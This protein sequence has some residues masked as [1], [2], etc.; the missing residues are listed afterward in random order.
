MTGSG[1]GRTRPRILLVATRSIDRHV[2]GSA[3]RAATA[4]RGL[5]RVG[6]VTYVLIDEQRADRPGAVLDP[7]VVVARR[8]LSGVGYRWPIVGSSLGARGPI[9]AAIAN[10][11]WEVPDVATSAEFDLGWFVKTAALQAWSGPLPRRIVLDVDDLEEDTRPGTPLRRSVDRMVMRGL[12]DRLAGKVDLLIAC[13]AAD[14]A[15]L[16]IGAPSA[17]VPN[18]APEVSAPVGPPATQPHLLFVGVLGYPPNRDGLTWFVRQVLPYLRRLTPGLVVRVV[19]PGAQALPADVRG[20]LE[21]VGIVADL[22]PHYAWSRIVVV[23]VLTGSGT[24]VKILDAFA[25][26]RGVVS[27]T[28]G[29]A[30]LE[31]RA[32]VDALIAD[33][34]R[35]FAHACAAALEPRTAEQL[36][37][38]GSA[39][40]TGRLSTATAETHVERAA[41]RALA[42]GGRFLVDLSSVRHWTGTP[43]GIARVESGLAR[44]VGS[45]RPAATACWADQGGLHVGSN[46]D[47]LASSDGRSSTRPGFDAD[48]RP[49]A[50]TALG[51]VRER[52]DRAAQV[53]PGPSADLLSPVRDVALGARDRRRRRQ[54]TRQWAQLAR[55]DDVVLVAGNDWHAGTVSAIAAL[56]PGRRPHLWVVVH[57]LLPLLHPEYAP[58]DAVRRRFADWAALV[59]TTATG[60]IASS[61][62]TAEAIGTA[63]D[64]G[65]LPRPRRLAVIHPA[66]EIAARSTPPRAAPA[67]APP[68]AV[69][70]ATIEAR[71][72]HALLVDV[73]RRARSAGIRLPQIVWVGSWGWGTADLREEIARDADLQTSI[74]HLSGLPDDEVRWIVEHAATVVYPSRFEGYG[75]PVAEAR[76]LGVP[77]I[78][79]DLPAVREA[80]GALA[81][82]LDPDDID[83]WLRAL[84]DVR[85]HPPAR[86]TPPA[87]RSWADVAGEL[88]AVVDRTRYGGGVSGEPPT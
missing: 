7:S 84:S 68:Y 17:V 64:R 48:H 34:P 28:V 29:A 67:L 54:G 27:T 42:P 82:F 87:A 66:V 61:G 21:V 44:G 15:Q 71:K 1:D 43:H 63:A 20:E 18:A 10:G 46:A 39:I 53:L 35:A 3:M 85:E 72:N 33:E 8:R 38:A 88:L 86:T 13:N 16:P 37:T 50:A 79:S 65:L 77:V 81:Q 4:R 11:R 6:D 75:L 59:M 14:Q 41:L 24:R 78:A 22:A 12:R 74:V 23:P 56:P 76:A 55:T 2:G 69:Y 30:G 57:D 31:V 5:E 9:A 58:D 52:V 51:R 60:V 80:A 19:G 49:P 83:G 26:G 40:A 32:G 45:L 73:V 47:L 25:H 62:A 36:A 70:V